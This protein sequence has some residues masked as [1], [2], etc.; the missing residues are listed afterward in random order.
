MN[1]KMYAT[2][3]SGINYIF[4]GWKFL[5]LTAN[6]GVHTTCT[7]GED[8]LFKTISIIQNA[9]IMLTTSKFELHAI[10]RPQL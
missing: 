1:F 8:Q 4:R 3:K 9:E 2:G 5:P 10:C 7:I 6:I